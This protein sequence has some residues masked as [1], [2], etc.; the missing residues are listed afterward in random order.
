LYHKCN[1]DFDIWKLFVS[2][3]FIFAPMTLT[4][5][6]IHFTK[7][8]AFKEIAK[9][10]NSFGGKYRAYLSRFNAGKLKHGAI[11][12]ILEANGY[13]IRSDKVEK[14]IV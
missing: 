7:S 9:Q 8:D 3:F 11:T 2:F 14:K 6:F 13:E 5:A 10:R 4:E 1:N 12:E